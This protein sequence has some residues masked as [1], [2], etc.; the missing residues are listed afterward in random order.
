[1]NQHTLWRNL[2]GPRA[3]RLCSRWISSMFLS[4]R[5]RVLLLVLATLMPA[6]LGVAWLIGTTYSA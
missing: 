6:I 1:M 2:H 4:I 3:H 5:S